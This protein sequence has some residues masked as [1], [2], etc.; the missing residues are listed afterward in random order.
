MSL[1]GN[2][3]GPEE[4]PEHPSVLIVA[5]RQFLQTP[6][7]PLGYRRAGLFVCV[8]QSPSSP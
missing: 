5:I 7:D 8:R 2:H 1:S 6:K 4:P 3:F